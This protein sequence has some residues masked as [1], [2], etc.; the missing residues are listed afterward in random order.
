MVNTVEKE[1]L[2][3]IFNVFTIGEVKE[4]DGFVF[5]DLEYGDVGDT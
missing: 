1:V 4:K 5:V 3:N 2:F